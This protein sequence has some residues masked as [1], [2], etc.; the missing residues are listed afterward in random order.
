[1][2]RVALRQRELDMEQQGRWGGGACPCG[3]CLSWSAATG[4]GSATGGKAALA[5]ISNSALNNNNHCPIE[6]NTV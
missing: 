1:M 5:N 2:L 3:S 4:C 6:Y